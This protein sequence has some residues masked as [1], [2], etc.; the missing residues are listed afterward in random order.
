MS[1]VTESPELKSSTANLAQRPQFKPRYD[2]YIGGKFTA[3]VKGEYF[4]NVSPIDGKVFTQAA[5]GTKEDI[6]AALDAAHAAFPAWRHDAECR[7]HRGHCTRCRSGRSR[8]ACGGK[9]SA[10]DR[11]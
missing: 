10:R 7:R 4:D 6:E 8:C 1:T 9:H 2:H 5:R 11:H 3:P